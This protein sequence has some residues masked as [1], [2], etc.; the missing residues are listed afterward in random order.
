VSG[1]FPDW[2]RGRL[3]RTAPAVFEHGAWSA[4]HWF[5][6]LGM[7]YRFSIEGP[8]RVVWAQ[9]LLDCEASRAALA[10]G[11][12]PLATFAS[13][14]GRPFWRR[15]VQPIPRR[16]DNANVNV[17]PMGPDWVAMTETDRQLAVDPQT[18]ETRREVPY[19]DDLPH[20]MSMTAHPLHDAER[21]L[22][23]NVGTVRG[24][25]SELVVYAHPPGS[26]RRVPFGRWAV[27]H[28]PY[29]HSFGLASDCA[30]LVAHPMTYRAAALL[31]SNR[32][33]EHMKWRP[34]EGTRLVAVD[35]ASGAI[36][37]YEADALFVFHT[38]NAFRDGADLVLDVVAHDDPSPMTQAFRVERIGEWSR[39]P[40]GRL[41]RV[42]MTP[43]RAR[44]QVE[45]LV[46]ERFEFPVVNPAVRGRKHGV[47]WGTI[48][49][50][51]SAI[52]RVDVERA[53][54]STF[55]SPGI[56]FGEALF[57]R[58][59]DATREDDGVLLAVGVEPTASRAKLVAVDAREMRPLAEAVVDTPIPLG[60]HGSFERDA[61]AS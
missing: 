39:P 49:G 18:L 53:E 12:I 44:A 9:R 19:D 26:R 38:V 24:A 57:V 2:L 60:F 46:G 14:N 56:V 15:L 4:R 6:G 42:R 23:V 32:F 54:A 36:T 21:D 16:T 1:A 31:W 11:R 41:T 3:I 51:E 43:G 47:V 48:V 17:V 5:D 59:P 34:E 55:S 22:V 37:V 35:R 10:T 30:V 29:V 45:P 52:V 28:L 40:L 61:A 27:R 8:D 13:G 25:R 20:G 33:V 7:L 58:A 50:A